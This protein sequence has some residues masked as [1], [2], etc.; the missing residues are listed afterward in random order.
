MMFYRISIDQPTTV[1]RHWLQYVYCGRVEWAVG[2][3]ND[4]VREIGE[5][6]R[7]RVR[8]KLK[9]NRNLVGVESLRQTFVTGFMFIYTSHTL[10]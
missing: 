8:Y 10:L 2:G 9:I 1:V 7:G 5:Y 3:E 6:G 4:G